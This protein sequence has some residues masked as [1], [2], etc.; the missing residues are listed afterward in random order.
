MEKTDMKKTMIFTLILMPLVVLAVL[1]FSGNIVNMSTYLYVEYIECIDDEIVLT[2]ETDED[3][4][5]QVKVNVF[6]LL[7]GN[8]EVEF[9]SDNP[10]IVS[11]SDNGK[12]TGHE[13][14]STYIYVT[15]KENSTKSDYVRV[16]VT[17]S[18]V[19]RIWLE[20]T[21]KN[22]YVGDTY[23]LSVKYAPADAVDTAVDYVSSNTAVATVDRNGKVTVVG[24]GDATITISLRKDSN[25]FT[26]FTLSAKPRL[27]GLSIAD[28]DDI[29]SA[30]TMFAFPTITELPSGASEK[31]SYKLS[32]DSPSGI[33][34]IDE[35]GNISFES[36][37]TVTAIAYVEGTDY[38]VEKTYTSTCG[39]FASIA[40]SLDSGTQFDY[41]DYVDK[42]LPIKFEY[43]PYDAD[44]SNLMVTSSNTNVVSCEDGKLTVLLG[45]KSTI[46]LSGM[47]VDGNPITAT[48]TISINRTSDKLAFTGDKF[49]VDEGN[50]FVYFA[51][52]EPGTGQ[53]M[54]T[55]DAK[56]L[57]QDANDEIH[58]ALFDENGD[59][60]NNNSIAYIVGDNLYFGSATKEAGY[61]K[62]KVMAYTDSGV[63]CEVI[64][65]YIDE[66]EKIDV[67]KTDLSQISRNMPYVGAGE[68]SFALVDYTSTDFSDIK[69]T[70]TSGENVI[71]QKHGAVFTLTN[72]G[73]ATIRV[74]YYNDKNQ[75]VRSK[76]IAVS[77]GRLVEKI[78]DISI[79]ALW[80]N[81]E[82]TY[83]IK[84]DNDQYQV[85][86]SAPKFEIGYSLYPSNT[87]LTSANISIVSSGKEGV[88][89]VSGNIITFV[90]CGSVSVQVEADGVVRAFTIRSTYLHPDSSTCLKDIPSS[91]YLT[92]NKGGS[93]NDLFDYLSVSPNN[94]DK[95]HISFSIDAGEE[96]ISLSG[97][98]VT[99]ISGNSLNNLSKIT[100]TVDLGG[101]E[102][103]TLDI[104]IYVVE[105][106]NGTKVSGSEYYYV[107]TASFDLADKFVVTSPTANTNLEMTCEVESGNATISGSLL[108]FRGA[109]R[110]VVSAKVNGANESIGRISVVYVGESTIIESN[111][112]VIIKGTKILIK[113]SLATLNKAKYSD[114]LTSSDQIEIVD[115]VFATI[116]GSGKVT[117]GEA[118]F[119]F[120]CLE[121]LSV[122]DLSLAPSDNTKY[123][124]SGGKY[125]TADTSL[126]LGWNYANDLAQDYVDKGYL[127]ANYSTT[128]SNVNNG[129]VSFAGAGDYTATIKL[130]YKNVIG[131][132]DISN[133]INISTTMG[134]GQISLTSSSIEVYY[135]E[136]DTSSNYIDI[137]KYLTISPKPLAINSNTVQLE[138]VGNSDLASI[139]GLKVRYHKGGSFEVKVYNL[140]ISN[141][142]LTIKIKVNRYASG[143]TLTDSTGTHSYVGKE[144]E[145]RLIVGNR[146][147][148]YISP[149]CYPIDAN[150][151]TE[152]EWELVSSSEDVASVPS[153]SDRIVF[154]KANIEVE[155][156]FTIGES[157]SIIVKF[158]TTDIM[159]EVDLDSLD[160]SKDNIIVTQEEEFTF[161]SK[162]MDTANI[163]I[164]RENGNVVTKTGGTFKVNES[165][166]ESVT[167]SDG[168]KSYTYL[169]ISAS[170]MQN[171]SA[172]SI[173]LKDT[174][175]SGNVVDNISS[176]DTHITAS[177]SVQILAKA[178]S[179]YD[180]DGEPLAYKFQVSDTTIASID[181]SGVIEFKK[182]GTIKVTI[183]V[184]YKTLITDDIRT[185]ALS[186][187]SFGE[188]V[189]KYECVIKSTF[190]EVTEFSI[191]TKEFNYLYDDM[192]SKVVD[193]I[194]SNVERT[195]PIYG[196]T[197]SD[198]ALSVSSGNSARVVNDSVE[199]I[200]SGVTKINVAMGLANHQ[201]ITINVNKKI[202]NIS[203]LESTKD[204]QIY[205]VVTKANTYTFRYSVAGTPMPN[206]LNGISIDAGSLSLSREFDSTTGIGKVTVGGMTA[207]NRYGISVADSV[208]KKS[209]SLY[210]ICVDS[211]VEVID[212]SSASVKEEALSKGIVIEAK[213]DYII[214]NRYSE[215]IYSISSNNINISSIGVFSVS[216]GC[217][218][219]ISWSCG[220]KVACI[221]Y[222]ATEDIAKFSMNSSSWADGFITA[223]GSEDDN[224]GIDLN[225][226][227]GASFLPTTAG[228]YAERDGKYIS[229]PYEVKY[230]ASG[231]G[232]YIKDGKLY[233]SKKDTTATISIY[234]DDDHTYTRKLT[235]TLGY[236]KE[237]TLDSDFMKDCYDSDFGGLVFNYG[238]D[239][240]SIPLSVDGSIYKVVSPVDAY[241][242]DADSLSITTGAD[243]VVEVAN[244]QTLKLVGG[245]ET[246]VKFRY[247]NKE[248]SLKIY[249]VNKAT[250]IKVLYKGTPTNYLVTCVGNN[251]SIAISYEI[252]NT[253]GAKL[254]P[255]SIKYASSVNIA[256]VDQ[257]GVIFFNGAGKVVISVSIA[258]ERNAS[259][260]SDAIDTITILNNPNYKIISVSKEDS[261]STDR[262][263][264]SLESTN[265]YVVYPHS[266]IEYSKIEY[267]VTT[268]E[269]I[270]S[271][272]ADGELT[273][274][275]L[276]GYATIYATAYKPD[277]GY[278][279]FIKHVYVWKRATLTLEEDATLTANNGVTAKTSWQLKPITNADDGSMENKTLSYTSSD[280]SIATVDSSGIITFK[281]AGEVKITVSVIYSGSAEV[282]KTF[283]IRSTCGVAEKFELY[284][285]LEDSKDKKIEHNSMVEIMSKEENKQTFEVR[286]V[287]PSDCTVTLNL[288]TNGSGNFEV[289]KLSETRFSIKGL[290]ATTSGKVMINVGDGSATGVSGTVMNVNVTIIE[291]AETIDIM[292]NNGVITGH[293]I[294]SFGDV[295]YLKAELNRIT[296]ST[297][298]SRKEIN[299]QITVG[300]EYAYFIKDDNGNYVIN[301][302]G[303]YALKITEANQ[304]ITVKATPYYNECEASASFMLITDISDFN[305]VVDGAIY[306]TISNSE[307][308]YDGYIFIGKDLSNK[309]E[310]TVGLE[311]IGITGFNDW[312]KFST[313]I[314]Y[315]KT[316]NEE[317]STI[318]GYNTNYGSK[319]TLESGSL[320]I[321]L[322]PYTTSPELNAIVTIT[323]DS[324]SL[325][326]GKTISKSLKIYRDGISS[327]EFYY[328]GDLMNDTLD[329]KTGLQQMLVFGTQSYYDGVKDY[330]NM[331]IKTTTIAG[332]TKALSGKGIVWTATDSSGNA[333]TDSSKN[334]INFANY[335]NASTEIIQMPTN[336][337]PTCLVQNMYDDAFDNGAVT[338][339]ASNLIGKELYTYTMH[340]VEGVNV[341]NANG[342]TSCG[343]KAVLHC[344]LGHDDELSS[345]LIGQDGY[346][347]DYSP[348][349]VV[350]GNGHLINLNARDEGVGGVSDTESKYHYHCYNN[351]Y[352]INTV[353]KGGNSGKSEYY[354]EFNDARMIAYCEVYNMYRAVELGSGDVYIKNSLLRNFQH[355]ALNLSNDYG[356]AR[357]VY[358]ENVI[359]FDVGQRAIELQGKKDSVHITGNVF[360][361]YNFQDQDALKDAVNIAVLG[362]GIASEIM[363]LAEKNSLTTTISTGKTWP[364]EKKWANFFCLATKDSGGDAKVLWYSNGFG[365]ASTEDIPNMGK[366]SMSY[367]GTTY[368][369]WAFK[370]THS[371]T[372]YD[373][374][375]GKY[376]S[377]ATKKTNMI[378]FTNKLE[379]SAT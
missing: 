14:G 12:I 366:V 168:T 182:A 217:D 44:I 235:S 129:L 251:Q 208:S 322:V 107:D 316:N 41:K 205:E 39:K 306:P 313:S 55:L 29:F 47:G 243:G 237:I 339:T 191:K 30:K 86:S 31:V 32:D 112:T 108:K 143:V 116:K 325:N 156:K 145:N 167:I 275:N 284:Q 52:F 209:A 174:D 372:W 320:T 312:T 127:V 274:N 315:Y 349:T 255:Y 173:K 216:T 28:R 260:T 132:T 280:E 179:G 225:Q 199:I 4:Y 105:R 289:K 298:V 15:S 240:I 264:L 227:Y 228:T 363:S 147:T 200:G 170:N 35:S 201:E 279:T 96:H 358:L 229:V 75:V 292:M 70:I 159:F 268:G 231:D 308:I 288:D 153:S 281:S 266:D 25:I 81:D 171:I 351:P 53:D 5:G 272:N 342:F 364:R 204:S 246:T 42:E 163:S 232:V 343:D 74:V 270:V 206:I 33:A 77:V 301:S 135:N 244:K 247:N 90:D 329:K 21:S 57:P 54:V 149:T 142:T 183:S 184:T 172:D 87:T 300:S 134:E 263:E 82:I 340:F 63:K 203:I 265:K 38:Y 327:V 76:D 140:T 91:G 43:T 94:V 359:M 296:H 78:N 267:K 253:S 181:N 365:E 80:Q 11:V 61:A 212:F 333:I 154:T 374:F 180:A 357:N 346:Y 238:H 56:S 162:D 355:S 336:T 118:T 310:I 136:D 120:V 318:N 323:Y 19:H 188:N 290:F 128:A 26:T 245:G 46:T 221:N 92:L 111:S 378:G 345:G 66:S 367:L 321:E 186:E 187:S 177:K 222:V 34:T 22:M 117:F 362:S 371:I 252:I 189:L 36:A 88:A 326:G 138:V 73:E 121:Q 17:S 248:T 317:D 368:A 123:T 155:V 278:D 69:Y 83:E 360:D 286:N 133:T 379:R 350:Y 178:L 9:R 220:E 89:S 139:E 190:G 236:A 97:S 210:I 256:T 233:F 207:G 45:G 297:T 250:G 37:G 10:E 109:G 273:F 58:Y 361:V 27:T 67:G 348:K 2:K 146:A 324:T 307:S 7:A 309:D 194:S 311:V 150:V 337:M 314:T 95:K 291:L 50:E 110:V 347:N 193:I 234:I 305:I 276:G 283:T 303:N 241:K 262:Y 259:G 192:S 331:S 102:T 218:G 72:K 93:I 144:D 215:D 219:Q 224:R 175:A 101:G 341:W 148:I 195:A 377:T 369:A 126:Q 104:M 48:S 130:S 160:P 122:N 119:E 294:S 295:I 8:K 113:P 137:S 226:Y 68:Y 64:V 84:N 214:E 370:N 185:I 375:D 258:S 198:M 16:I 40:F 125:V 334:A 282:S 354:T 65:T 71:T 352:W 332:N 161:I 373:E 271:I 24:G 299:W 302:D 353:I 124:L 197:T 261:N 157:K 356:S 131:G 328:G 1:L 196:V 338:I 257:N 344:D 99:A 166:K 98:K 18:R 115:Q 269:N 103:K 13:F 164:T 62:V 287:Y 176:L 20:E 277:T 285:I 211:G 330:Y 114:T 106:A 6:P 51:Y 304:L 249:V 239:D 158:K 242:L 60:I 376:S 223:M 293:T 100:I 152:I 151:G 169:M 213:Q 319:Y 230:S 3:V 335:Y 165:F 23:N 254:S 141:K 49:N 59:R 79:K 85:Y 202:D